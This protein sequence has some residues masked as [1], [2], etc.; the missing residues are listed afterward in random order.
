MESFA[1][2]VFINFIS[3]R[4]EKPFSNIIARFKFYKARLS[5]KNDI[6]ESIVSKHEN[7]LYYNTLDK[8]LDQSNYAE[9]IIGKS[10]YC[11]TTIELSFSKYIEMMVQSF[12][13]KNPRFTIY[14][15]QITCILTKVLHIVFDKINNYSSDETARLI[16]TN[17]GYKL[18]GV[19]GKVD[20][21]QSTFESY[22][23]NLSSPSINEESIKT[24]KASI[25]QFFIDKKQY[26]PRNI[27]TGNDTPKSSLEELLKQKKI[28]LLGDPGSGKTYETLNLLGE[29]CISAA[30]DKCIPI[31]LRLIEYG[32]KYNS[33]IEAAS[34]KMSPFCGKLE[35][36][37]IIELIKKEQ[38]VLIL[39]GIDEI[40]NLENRI[41]FYSDLNETMR[42]MTAYCFITSRVNQ[43][44]GDINNIKQYCIT[45]ISQYE[46]LQK[47]RE[48]NIDCEILG[49]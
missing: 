5:L 1:V 14:K 3:N 9:N 8:F 31:Y 34:K 25:S 13:D 26:I 12:V 22:V 7:E 6:K 4:L 36:G 47:L 27:F 40:I 33:L 17:L 24:Y 45:D 2:A 48:N 42:Y 29:V 18:S 11:V 37:A 16:V 19:E 49:I 35:D 41:K 23:L 15:N 28:L 20:K 43:Y 21:L 10:Y 32:I 39:D 46:I 44:H 30:F 38:I